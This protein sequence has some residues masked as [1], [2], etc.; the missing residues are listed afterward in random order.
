MAAHILVTEGTQKAL[1]TP[2]AHLHA[3]HVAMKQRLKRSGCPPPVHIAKLPASPE[4]CKS[5]YPTVYNAVFGP[6]MEQPVPCQV[7]KMMMEQML[8]TRFQRKPKYGRLYDNPVPTIDVRG[9]CNLQGVQGVAQCLMQGM[10]AMQ[11]QQQQF[12]QMMMGGMKDQ[13]G[14]RSLT[15]PSAAS[16]HGKGNSPA[17]LDSRGSVLQRLPT[18]ALQNKQSSQVVIEEVQHESATEGAGDDPS[19]EAVEI[20]L[21]RKSPTRKSPKEA[22]DDPSREAVETPLPWKSPTRKPP[23]EAGNSIID[24]MAKKSQNAKDKRALMKKPAAAKTAAK[25]MSK[26][27][28]GPSMSV[29]RSRSQIMLRNGQE[30]PGTTFK[31]KFADYGGEGKA[32]KKARTWLES[33]R[34]KFTGTFA[35]AM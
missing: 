34:A 20:P 5:Q 1:S 33:E 15:G 9:D 14:E 16:C 18:L 19:R 12:M 6:G 31:M 4:E 27:S 22:G 35:K 28:A 7:S 2:P 26:K 8:H 25:K 32:L 13:A 21:P 24:M 10:Q 11:Q 29:E 30:G 17:L 3:L 23:K